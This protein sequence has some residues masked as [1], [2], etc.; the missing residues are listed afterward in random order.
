MPM[1]EEEGPIEKDGEY[2][3]DVYTL[4]LSE[5]KRDRELGFRSPSY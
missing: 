3:N 1:E 2:K 4:D 5:D